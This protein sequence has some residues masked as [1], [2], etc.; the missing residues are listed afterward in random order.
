MHVRPVNTLVAHRALL[1]RRVEQVVGGGVRYLNSP[2]APCA[3][4]PGAGMAFQAKLRD[5]R[6]SEQL[7]VRRPVRAMAG[8]AALDLA[9]AMFE[10]ERSAFVHVA[11]Q[12]R[13]LAAVRLVEHP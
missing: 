10:D 2:C 12:A 13:L 3:E 11:L 8:D 9:R 5:R 6:P 7:P 1:I 4:T